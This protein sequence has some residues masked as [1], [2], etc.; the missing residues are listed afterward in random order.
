VTTFLLDTNVLLALSDQ[1]HIH[2]ERAH[3]WFDASGGSWATCSITENGFVRIASRPSY[4]N[5]PGDAPTV[6]AIL[7]QLVR[8]S[9]HQ[10]W[11]ADVSILDV[12]EPDAVITPSQITDTYL[13]GLAAHRGGKLATL[14]TRIPVH[15]VHGGREAIEFVIE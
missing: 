13:L 11:A 14:D 7:R 8:V 6:L 15:A 9:G 10:F 12:L 5:P 3:R 1:Q 2:Y 4:P